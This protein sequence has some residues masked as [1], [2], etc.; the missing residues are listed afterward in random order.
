MT[1]LKDRIA[2]MA[3]AA[4]EE[5]NAIGGGK[6]RETISGTVGRACRAGQAW[7]PAVRSMIEAMPWFGR[8]HCELQAIKEDAV[9]AA[10]AGL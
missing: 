3:L 2:N 10:L 6:A 1:S 8:G 5:F 9:R 4:D 7:A